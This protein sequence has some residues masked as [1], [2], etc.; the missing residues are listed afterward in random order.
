MKKLAGLLPTPQGMTGDV[1]TYEESDNVGGDLLFTGDPGGDPTCPAPAVPD[2]DILDDDATVH[3]RE[4]EVLQ[5]AAL[6]VP[7]L[8]GESDGAA[9]WS[10]PLAAVVLLVSVTH[11]GGS[12][13][14]LLQDR[15][16]GR[17]FQWR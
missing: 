14:S 17:E 2:S 10:L 11:Q 12:L 9:V 16:R 15:R 1:L 8:L 3:V 13:V 4:P 6:S 7:R 5:P